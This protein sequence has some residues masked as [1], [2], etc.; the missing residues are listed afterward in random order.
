MYQNHLVFMVNKTR[1][2]HWRHKHWH[3]ESYLSPI[4]S[5]ILPLA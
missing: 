4:Y 2:S 1:E 3:M 5:N